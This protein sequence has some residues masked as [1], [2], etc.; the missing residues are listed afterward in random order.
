MEKNAKKEKTL[1]PIVTW[2]LGIAYVFT[3]I[4][5]HLME[6]DFLFVYSPP[7]GGHHCLH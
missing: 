7:P 4:E 1:I 2:L 5:Q 3:V 6:Y